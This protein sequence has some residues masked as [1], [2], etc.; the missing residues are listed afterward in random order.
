MNRRVY[1]LIYLFVLELF[2]LGICGLYAPQRDGLLGVVGAFRLLDLGPG[3]GG[4]IRSGGT[5]GGTRIR[6]AGGS[7]PPDVPSL[8]PKYT[9]GGLDPTYAP[10]P[11][12]RGPVSEPLAPSRLFV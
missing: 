10:P 2:A 5:G 1:T 9:S 12:R 8:F 11:Q 6:R 3:S 7:R 4:H